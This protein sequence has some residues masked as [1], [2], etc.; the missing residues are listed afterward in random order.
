MNGKINLL[1]MALL[2]VPLLQACET[3]AAWEGTITDSAGVAIVSNTSTPLWSGDEA[4]TADEDLRI[5]TVAGEPE[6]QFGQLAFLDVSHDGRI[7]VTDAQAQEVRVYDSQGIHLATVGGPGGGPGELGPGAAFVMVTPDGGMV[8][9]DLANTRVNRYGADFQ[10]LGSFPI[11]IEAGIPT[12]WS[13]DD[14][15]RLMAQL[16]GINVQGIAALE[17]GDPIVVYDT[18]GTVVDTV[19]LLPKGQMLEGMSEQQF[20]MT[21]FA[22][23][24]V[25]DLAD[26]G[27]VYYA[28]NDRF[29][30][31]VNDPQGNLVRIIRKDFSRKAV[32]ES[33]QNAI[34]R[35]LREQWETAGVPPA[36]IE[37]LMTGVG[38][39]ETYPAFGQF[40]LGPEGT[41]W[42]QRIRSARD[43]AEAAGE[44]EVEFNPQDIGSP[45]WEVF[46]GQ[47]RFLGVV[48]LPNLFRPVEAVGDQ[49][50][51]I[52]Q[53]ELDVQYIMRVRVNRPGVE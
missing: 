32:E 30:V 50:Y 29:R 44:E 33:D 42:V 3:S 45:D 1:V 40:F 18:T 37:Q 10:P 27:S 14:A 13:M 5:G 7:F 38:F 51:G 41:L 23:E 36:Q 28:L 4:W 17:E 9:P 12:I 20:S 31:L 11:T 43:M 2:A 48:S 39:A 21:I 26:D 49:I 46:D 25:W 15:G 22:P 24:P 19:A 16:R 47:G 53:D 52:W 6:Y 34:L 8:V 35:L